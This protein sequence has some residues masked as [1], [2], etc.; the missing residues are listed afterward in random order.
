MFFP[1]SVLIHDLHSV[2]SVGRVSLG[3]RDG[4][5]SFLPLRAWPQA[6]GSLQHRTLWQ[7]TATH[8]CPFLFP[9]FFLIHDLP[10]FIK[11]GL[12][13][14]IPSPQMLA[15]LTGVDHHSW[16]FWPLQKGALCFTL[17]VPASYGACKEKRPCLKAGA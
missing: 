13:H 1:V 8:F 11:P 9:A 7:T 16:L 4:P 17:K 5:L 15:L 14:V 12:K 3:L 2:L 10:T 6:Q